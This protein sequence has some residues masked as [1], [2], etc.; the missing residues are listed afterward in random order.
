MF[1]YG[2]ARQF[3]WLLAP[4]VNLRELKVGAGGGKWLFHCARWT[5]CS[6]AAA[7]PSLTTLDLQGNAW[8][9]LPCVLKPLTRCKSLVTVHLDG[10][11]I[12]D[13][14]PEGLADKVQLSSVHGSH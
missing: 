14:L 12:L 11:L 7:L 1:D 8:N 6:A 3:M 5:L 10:N 13:A 2:S 9:V 4:L